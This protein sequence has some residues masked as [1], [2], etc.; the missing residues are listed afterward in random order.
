MIAEYGADDDS[1]TLIFDGG[2]PP[3][4]INPHEMRELIETAQY[5]VAQRYEAIGEFT[6]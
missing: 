2:I 4:V 3:V 6:V 1:F 5:A